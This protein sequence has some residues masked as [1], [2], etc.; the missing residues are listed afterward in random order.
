MLEPAKYLDAICV[1]LK[2][3]PEPV[4][5]ADHHDPE[6]LMTPLGGYFA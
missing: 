6:N 4:D 2:P 5:Q 3:R 1:R